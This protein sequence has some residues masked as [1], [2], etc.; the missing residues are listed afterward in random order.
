MFNF[1]I[2]PLGV[3]CDRTRKTCVILTAVIPSNGKRIHIE[4]KI[5]KLFRSLKVVGQ[6]IEDL[7]ISMM[8][9]LSLSL[10]RR[11]RSEH[12]TICVNPFYLIVSPFC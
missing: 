4:Y 6:D 7:H 3:A 1:I 11:T 12:I 10:M 5:D 2:N 8:F 9:S